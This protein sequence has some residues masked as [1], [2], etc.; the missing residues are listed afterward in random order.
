MKLLDI[1]DQVANYINKLIAKAININFLNLWWNHFHKTNA[2]IAGSCVLKGLVKDTNVHK[3]E[4]GDIDIWISASNQDAIHYYTYLLAESGYKYYG[5][6]TNNNPNYSRLSKYVHSIHSYKK[7]NSIDIQI[8]FYNTQYTIEQVVEAFD[9]SITRF[10]IKTIKTRNNEILLKDLKASYPET[11]ENQVLK[12]IFTISD[13]ALD[14][15]SINEWERTLTRMIK[16]TQRGFK[17]DMNQIKVLIHNINR[18]YIQKINPNPNPNKNLYEIRRYYNLLLQ[19][20]LYLF[21][22]LNICNVYLE[23]NTL[24]IQQDKIQCVAIKQDAMCYN[25]IE[26]NNIPLTDVNP[27]EFIVIG[28]VLNGK[29]CGSL[30]PIDHNL[31]KL[32]H[33]SIDLQ[34]FCKNNP[35]EVYYHCTNEDNS[36]TFHIQDNRPYIQISI[37]QGQYLVNY[38]N[39]EA[40]QKILAKNIQAQQRFVFVF[41]RYKPR[42]YLQNTVSHGAYL[43]VRYDQGT[44]MG[45]HNCQPGTVKEVC[46]LKIFYQKRQS[47]HP[48]GGHLNYKAN[49]KK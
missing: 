36:S 12:N 24:M 23:G 35:E 46:Q 41:K 15:Q 17:Y 21:Q 8:I 34:E 37:S 25:F 11:Y 30:L 9:I 26:L 13:L 27:N 6:S 4:P 18:S 45:R 29:F 47:D 44:I 1:I 40:I 16:Y 10:M 14:T 28:V 5:P 3:W 19:R 38:N 32:L 43:A 33:K 22:S 2:T 48:S 20:L 39:I 42:Q 49:L 31:S 7:Y